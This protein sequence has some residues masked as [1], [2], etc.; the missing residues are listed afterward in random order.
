[1]QHHTDGTRTRIKVCLNLRENKGLTYF[2]FLHSHTD[3]DAYIIF[4]FCCLPKDVM[5][6][7]ILGEVSVNSVLTFCTLCFDKV[8]NGLEHLL[9][10]T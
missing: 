10:K 6:K 1:M 4:A 3:L 5:K 8:E 2:A 9:P 7:L